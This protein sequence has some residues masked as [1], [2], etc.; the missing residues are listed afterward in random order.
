[1]YL[2]CYKFQQNRQHVVLD[3][4]SCQMIKTLEVYNPQAYIGYQS[5]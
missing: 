5:S 2:Y 4:P 1:M 3:F